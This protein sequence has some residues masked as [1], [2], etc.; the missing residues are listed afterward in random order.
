ML[1]ILSKNK[2]IFILKINFIDIKHKKF[3]DEL[4]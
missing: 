2:Y 3:I 4:E 1:K